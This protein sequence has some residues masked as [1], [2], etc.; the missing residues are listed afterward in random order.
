[1]SLSAFNH[2]LVCVLPRAEAAAKPADDDE[3]E[4]EEAI[5][6]V[7]FCVVCFAW[8]RRLRKP[9]QY[10]ATRVGSF[11]MGILSKTFVQNRAEDRTTPGSQKKVC[12]YIYI[13]IYMYICQP[14]GGV[15]LDC[16]GFV[17]ANKLSLS[18]L[19]N[20]GVLNY[21]RG[22]QRDGETGRRN[23]YNIIV[24]L[25]VVLIILLGALIML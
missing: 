12:I 16:F 6:L 10:S 5:A 17:P 24:N 9:P 8:I 20:G 19:I 4:E 18:G 14:A 11:T 21:R 13:Y 15:R 22:S 1:M 23:P 2:S 3:D 25:L 7:I